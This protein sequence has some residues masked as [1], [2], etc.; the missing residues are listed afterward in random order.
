MKTVNSSNDGRTNLKYED[1]EQCCNELH[2]LAKKMQ[3]TLNSVTDC[4]NTIQN[5]SQWDDEGAYCYSVKLKK[6]VSNFDESYNEIENAV[7]YMANC[8]DG[9]KAIDNTV[10]NEICNNLG[11]NTPNLS[12]SKLFK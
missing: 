4:A 12:T 8:S 2:S 10:I 3:D 6:L 5:G 11:I 7:L 9:Y 1:V